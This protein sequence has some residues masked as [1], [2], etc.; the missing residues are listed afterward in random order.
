MID[1][2]TLFW[3]R[4]GRSQQKRGSFGG[5]DQV[6]ATLIYSV[7][8]GV[9]WI[10]LDALL[11]LCRVRLGTKH[12]PN[13]LFTTGSFMRTR[14]RKHRS[15]IVSPKDK[16]TSGALSKNFCTGIH[17]SEIHRSCIIYALP[18]QK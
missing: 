10:K 11:R 4:F 18:E 17:W 2:V 7:S 9:R 3:D 13:C 5:I 12:N 8:L 15:G 6:R 16:Y 1:E 14:V